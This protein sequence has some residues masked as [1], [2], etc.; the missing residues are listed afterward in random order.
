MEAK[1]YGTN[2]RVATQ[3]CNNSLILCNQIPDLDPSVYENM[4]FALEDE[5]TGEMTEIYPWVLTDCSNDEVNYLEKT[6]GL[7]FTYSDLLDLYILCVPH[8]GTA[9]DYVYCETINPYAARELGE[10]K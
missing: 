3:W 6:F 4:H 2:Y 7:L 8:W 5:E 10:S 1:T 9:W